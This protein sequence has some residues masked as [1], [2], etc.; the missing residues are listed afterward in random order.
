MRAGLRPEPM[1]PHPRSAEAFKLRDASSY[2]PVVEE[3]GRYVDRFSPPLAERALALARVA[4]GDRVLDVG[5]G[6]GIVALAAARLVGAAGRVLAVDLSQQ[7]LAAA[8]VRAAQA[9][10]DDRMDFRVMDAEQL[11]LDA[12]SFSVAT[13][14]FALL[15]FPNPLTALREQ[16]RVLEPGGR[17]VVGVGSRPPLLSL[18]GLAHRAA[19][20]PKL[21]SELVGLR[22][23]AP[24]LLDR[25]VE[26]HF[27]GRS[28]PEQS[29]LADASRT[30]TDSVVQ[31]VRRAGFTEIRTHWE[32]HE[33]LI[34]D[35]EE[36][37]LIQRTFSSVARKRIEERS[38]EEVEALHAD[39]IQQCQTTQ[40]RGGRLVYPFAAFF[41]AAVRP[42]E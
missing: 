32:G 24:M 15:H 10:L 9:R 42:R 5:A 37:W 40:A 1:T 26:E 12:R 35:P 6:T 28:A 13:S 31:L 17:I 25:L 23:V 16:F 3:F 19:H 4:P 7:M 30:R 8:A 38:P 27:P 29:D 33:A 41:V 22:S 14:L 11:Q 21:I 34:A 20:L 2:D 18:R 36:F 39:F